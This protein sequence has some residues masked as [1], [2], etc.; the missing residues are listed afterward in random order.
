MGRGCPVVLTR[1]SG[2]FLSVR[3]AI[4]RT[5]E[6]V[7]PNATKL[8]V[9]SEEQHVGCHVMGMVLPSTHVCESRENVNTDRTCSAG[10]AANSVQ[11]NSPRPCVCDGT[12]TRQVMDT[13]E[14]SV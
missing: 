1:N 3:V 11:V 13:G 2:N 12:A 4:K 10:Q 7:Q 5:Q 9:T 6:S 14:L 8:P